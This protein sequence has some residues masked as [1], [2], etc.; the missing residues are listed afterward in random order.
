MRHAYAY[1]PGLLCRVRSLQKKIVTVLM[2]KKIYQIE[3]KQYSHITYVY[4]I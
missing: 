2:P 3:H 1:G 4:V